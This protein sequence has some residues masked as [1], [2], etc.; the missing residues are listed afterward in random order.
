MLASS[1]SYCLNDMISAVDEVTIAKSEYSVE[2]GS[3]VVNITLDRTGDLL[4]NI[5][6]PVRTQ[7]IPDATN[8]AIRK[9]LN[10]RALIRIC[11]YI[12][13]WMPL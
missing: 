1:G 5:T 2:E 13:E 3:G 12:I 6:I 8:A 4:D 7:A 10:R 11:L 9:K